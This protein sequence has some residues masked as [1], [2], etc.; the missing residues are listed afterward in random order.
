MATWPKR[1]RVSVG[2]VTGSTKGGESEEFRA[3]LDEHG[4]TTQKEDEQEDLIEEIG[5]Y[6]FTAGIERPVV[7]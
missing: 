6:A 4:E 7:V 5:V 3:R 2:A 1:T